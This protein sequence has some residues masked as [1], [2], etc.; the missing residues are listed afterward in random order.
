MPILV[1]C[2]PTGQLDRIWLP[3]L[4]SMRIVDGSRHLFRCRCCAI[5]APGPWRLRASAARF[6]P[7]VQC[8]HCFA[9]AWE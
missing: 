7:A 4:G 3:C 1:W 2:C 6:L 9:E 5:P 8:T